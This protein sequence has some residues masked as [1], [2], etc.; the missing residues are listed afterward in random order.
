M[1]K[2]FDNNQENVRMMKLIQKISGTFRT[3]MGADLFC[4]I[5]RSIYPQCG[6]GHYMLDAIQD[7]LIGDPFIP[8]AV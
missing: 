2:P 1:I 8:S 6:N 7:A 4:S 5:L 3:T